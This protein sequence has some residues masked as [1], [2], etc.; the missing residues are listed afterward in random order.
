MVKGR[1]VAGAVEGVMTRKGAAIESATRSKGAMT[2]SDA[3]LLI[4]LVCG[5]MWLQLI[6]ED[7]TVPSMTVRW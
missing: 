6:Q 1:G 3:V 2:A 4:L 7:T 5:N